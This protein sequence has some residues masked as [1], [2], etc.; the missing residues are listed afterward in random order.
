MRCARGGAESGAG[1]R[2][3]RAAMARGRRR[4]GRPGARGRPLG[5]RRHRR[6][7][8][9]R[10]RAQRRRRGQPRRAGRLGTDREGIGALHRA[11]ARTSCPQPADRGIRRPTGARCRAACTMPPRVRG[12]VPAHELQPGTRRPP[13]WST[14]GGGALASFRAL[15]AEVTGGGH[16]PAQRL[17]RDPR[18]LVVDGRTMRPMSQL[19]RPSTSAPS[20]PH[21]KPSITS[22]KPMRPLIQ[23]T[24]SS[25]RPFT[26]NEMSP[27]V[28]TYS[29]NATTRTKV[30]TI[31]FT[32]PKIRAISRYVSTVARSVSSYG[33]PRDARDDE[34]REPQ[35]ERRDDD[36]HDEA[37]GPT[38][39]EE[40]A[41][42]KGYG[43]IRDRTGA[44]ERERSPSPRDRRPSPYRQGRPAPARATSCR[45]TRTRSSRS[46][47]RAEA[48]AA[49]R[50]RINRYP[51]ATALACASGSPSATA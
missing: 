29:G 5:R 46:R 19:M 4:A 34:G 11:R 23:A 48:I 43:G 7:P 18:R 16:R 26:M 51:D 42:S 35:G 36:L 37:H 49:T 2:A 17:G 21:Q 30:P 22:P 39:A 10:P 20:T 40:R 27:S 24:S 47:R 6:E 45:A 1:E 9:G 31:A 32:R 8:R 28:S 15:V 25:S 33:T 44:H 14:S 41:R 38:L 12:R 50:P 13:R 3:V